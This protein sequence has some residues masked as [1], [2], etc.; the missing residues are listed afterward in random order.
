MNSI[1]T[2]KDLNLYYGAAH[3]LKNVNIDIAENSITALIGPSGCGKSTFLKTLNRMN[4]LIPGVR[5][6]GDVRYNGMDIFGKNV[7]V[8]ELRREIGM[9]FQKPNP[10]P[11]SIYDNI[12][13]GPR[14]HGIKNKAALDEIV[15][16]SLT[17][18]AIWDEVKDRLKKSAL[19]L[20]GGQQQR[21]CIAR[22]LAVKP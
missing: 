19:G 2:V 11:M 9:V 13:Y 7:D 18:A 1:I 21:L 10:F 17:G 14:T 22:A 6:E 20:S 3:A 15:E 5:I 8:N 16:E 4:D 12:A